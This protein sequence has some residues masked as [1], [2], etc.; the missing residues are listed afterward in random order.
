M[1][2]LHRADRVS[3]WQLLQALMH[4]RDAGPHNP[5]VGIR[6]NTITAAHNL[7]YGDSWVSWTNEIN[8]CCQSWP[9]YSGNYECPVPDVVNANGLRIRDAAGRMYWDG[10]VAKWPRHM[11]KSAYHYLPETPYAEDRVRLLH[12]CI[13]KVQEELAR[14]LEV[15]VC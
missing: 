10:R 14:R 9:L 15:F 13:A 3:L 12:W 6:T 5:A 11:T 8:E 7:G 4:I 2:A 1:S